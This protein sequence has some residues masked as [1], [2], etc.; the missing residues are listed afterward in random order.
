MVVLRRSWGALSTAWASW[1]WLGKGSLASH[2][3]GR[4][5]QDAG[6]G[7]GAAKLRTLELGRF[8]AATIIVLTHLLLWVNKL[9]AAGADPLLG[10]WR[11]PGA[12]GV[13]YFFV[14]SGFV[15]MT[16]H[17]GDWG[18]AAAV[19]RFWWRRLCRIYPTYWL[20]LL[21]PVYYLHSTVAPASLAQ[22]YLLSPWHDKD[23]IPAAWSLR[24]ELV[25]YFFF[26]LA[27]MP[28]VGR[29]ILALWIG[30]TLWRWVPWPALDMLRLPHPTWLNHV[31]ETYLGERLFSYFNFYFIAGLAAGW[32]F[33]K[34]RPGPQASLALLALGVVTILATLP[35]ID[36]GRDYGTPAMMMRMSVLFAV[37][38]LGLVGLERHGML[39]LGR[40]ADRAG[41][42]SYPLYILHMPLL[43]ALELNLPAFTAGGWAL[44]GLFLAGL[45]LLY[46]ASLLVSVTFDQPMQR[47]LRA[48]GRYLGG[49]RARPTADSLS[50]EAVAPQPPSF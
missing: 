49:L 5:D 48:L 29:P 3:D 25:F 45:L 27:L 17:H 9:A 36:W 41:A 18:D 2:A 42:L 46:A 26:G 34:R 35:E 19:P 14:L 37:T 31:V 24:H 44:R 22:M 4:P 8:L 20:A 28:R 40:L 11:P 15:M 7:A 50:E 6:V 39:R 16:A 47:A 13:T 10:G 33:L 30:A 32:I 1:G 38:L 43:L 12:F 21:I 23:F